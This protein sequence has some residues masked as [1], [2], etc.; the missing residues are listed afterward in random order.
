VRK[1]RVVDGSGSKSDERP[2]FEVAHMTSLLRKAKSR[3]FSTLSG[4][5]SPN[6]TTSGRT[7]PVAENANSSPSGSNSGVSPSDA[8]GESAPFASP[9]G[10]IPKN[11]LAFRTIT[12]L[13]AKLQHDKPLKYSNE[14]G[15]DQ[16]EAEELRISTAF[17]NLA[18]TDI[19]VIAIAASTSNHKVEVIACANPENKD[20]LIGHLPSKMSDIWK[21]L[22][23]SNPR[24]DDDIGHRGELEDM[25]VPYIIDTVGPPGVSN[26]L[27]TLQYYIGN[28]WCVD[29]LP[30][31]HMFISYLIAIKSGHL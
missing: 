20:E 28:E 10:G 22:F 14:P 31:R 8:S 12:M 5:N 7:I 3:I 27:E 17:A 29:C 21:L 4:S 23:S 26:D 1:N 25:D 30:S 6:D 15:L 13:L 19:D 18:N 16:D 11:I 2:S 24:R 9:P